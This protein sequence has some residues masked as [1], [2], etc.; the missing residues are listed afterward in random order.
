MAGRSYAVLGP[1]GSGKSTLLQVI[2]SSLTP[3]KGSIRYISD[4]ETVD[5]DRVYRLTSIAAP[6]MELVEEFTLAEHVAFHFSFKTYRNGFDARKLIELTGLQAAQDKPIRYFSSG[7][8]QRVK[9]ALACCADT[10]ILLLDE[11]TSNLDRAG[12]SW[13]LELVKATQQDRLLII[14]SNQEEE[15][16][17]CTESI[18]ITDYKRS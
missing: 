12:V 7:M 6:Y 11:P 1:N 18:Q 3:S 8:R 16:Q 14:C 4:G 10:P 2:A 15:Y 17:F 13:Y 9:L 5:V